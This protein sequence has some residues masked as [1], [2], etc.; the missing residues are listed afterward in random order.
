MSELVNLSETTVIK[1]GNAF[2]VALRDGRLP[3]ADDHPLGIYLADCRH[4]RGYELWIGGR[5]PRLLISNDSAGAGAVFE[6]TNP[7][8]TLSD[9]NQL[10]LQALQI[11]LDRQMEPAAM[12]E[13]ISLRSHAREA[14]GFD[15]EL[16]LDADFSP[17][18]EVRGLV[19]PARRDVAR[20]V[21]AHALKFAA[22]GVD[23]VERSTTVGCAVAEAQEDGCL[24]V[25]VK[26]APGEEVS[27]DVRFELG[28]G[29]AATAQSIGIMERDPGASMSQAGADADAW[30]AG[31]CRVEVDDELVDRV[32]RRSL[33]DLRLLASEL[34]G[35]RYYAAGVPW[36]A[37][38]FGRDSIITAQQ[39]LAFDPNMAAE[40]LRVLA[41]RLGSTMDDERDE[42][43]G[44]VLH[45]LRQDELAAA[46][47][48]PFARYYGT[49]DATPLFLCLLCEQ[50]NWTGSLDLFHELAPQIDQALR[51]IDQFGDL[52][53]DE[54]LEYRRRSPDGLANHCW[55]D[56]WDGVPD[57]HGVPLEPPVAVIEAQG[58]VVAA[59]RG[60]ARLFE[61]D[62]EPDRAQ[63]LRHEAHR[64]A[65][66]LERFWLPDR[67]FY[68]MALD[69]QKRATRVLSSNQGH[70]LWAGAVSSDRAEA[71]CRALMSGAAYSGWGVRT[72]SCEERAFNPVGYH[73]GTVWP[74]DN[75][76]F[77]IGLRKYGLDQSFL[78]ILESLLDAASVLPDY[79][80]PE[81]FAG[82]S[83]SDY[84]DPVPYPVACTPQA[85]AAGSLPA[86]LIAGLGI[87]ADGLQRTLRIRR[88]SLPRQ[89]GR[90]Y[91]EHLRV[92][93]AHVDLLFERVAHRTESVALTDVKID[94]QLD[95]VLEILRAPGHEPRARDPLDPLGSG[96]K[97]PA[98][99]ARSS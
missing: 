6:L 61:L 56:S 55:K 26:L 13:R 78:R 67:G 48:T 32:L 8:L 24:C 25:A 35:Q 34:D 21:R 77:A 50:A 87:T 49:V 88:P 14:V 19:Q 90:V 75:A 58:Y 30:L 72:L 69:R 84:E 71:I 73:T 51:W 93:D 60:L 47:L 29:R 86:M 1:A 95:V 28:E 7:D 37:T 17:M 10:P 59:K 44:K 18:L 81:L 46:G 4:L 85:W 2:C 3:L 38:L 63:R 43:P 20:D 94:G 9:G 39:T 83:R 53:G 80:L 65:G 66:Q 91:V 41:G 15:V 99:S 23:G 22:R 11:R 82:F 79:R 16:R 74:H 54:L 62:G 27:L 57:E 98:T 36:Y 40:T 12:V 5:R 64:V 92:G 97:P 68:A 52:D 96:T 45:E 89:V 33:L 76:L 70:L 42:E 31:R